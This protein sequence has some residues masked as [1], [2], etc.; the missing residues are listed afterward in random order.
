MEPG[1]L[2]SLLCPSFPASEHFKV[3]DVQAASDGFE[4]NLRAALDAVFSRGV[5]LPLVFLAL[6]RAATY[7]M[8][9][10]VSVSLLPDFKVQ[11]ST[12]GIGLAAI[13]ATAAQPRTVWRRNSSPCSRS[14]RGRSKPSS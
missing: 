5:L 14:I 3:P 9:G 11:G 8:Q 7:L 6:L 12:G 1:L 10:L 13:G 4:R 2:L